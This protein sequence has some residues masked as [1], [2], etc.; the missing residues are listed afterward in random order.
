M[1]LINVKAFLER[2]Q[3]MVDGKHVNRRT[4]VLEFCDDKST[5]YAILS[6]RWIDPTEVDYEDIVD[7]AKMNVEERDEIRQRRGYR[8]ILDTCEQAKRDGYEWVWVD[9]CCIDKRSSAELSEAINSMY[10]WYANSRVCY[11]YLHDVDGSSIPA[12]EDRKKYP[13]SNGWPEWF[14]R[15]WTLQEMIA[16]SNVQFF[17]MNWT[18]IGDKQALASTLTNIT[19]VPEYI[20]KEGLAGNRP[21]V[22][23]IMS[24]AAYRKTSRVED[25]AYSLMGLLDVNMPMLY[26]EGRKAFHRL[27]LEIIR[28]SND[29]SIFAWGAVNVRIGSVLADDP[30]SFWACSDMELLDHDE[31]IDALKRVIPQAALPSIDHDCSD[32]FPITNRGI[33]NW[34][35][36][37]P[38][39]DSESVFKAY[40]PCCNFGKPATID[41]ALRNSN[42]Y[43]YSWTFDTPLENFLQFRQIYL[44]YQDIPCNV[45]FEIDDS[46]ITE[47]GFTC[48]E[49][50]WMEN[51]STLTATDT[52]RVRTY[53]ERQGNGR[54][55][56][57]F[58]HYFGQ[59]WIHLINHPPNRFTQADMEKLVVKGPCRSQS[60]A[61]PPSRGDCRGRIWVHHMRLPTSI[62][63]VRTH[64]V[65]WERSRI[66]IKLEI[67]PNYRCQN[68][69]NEWKTFDIEVCDFSSC[70]W[71][72]MTI[73]REPTTLSGT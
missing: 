46:A 59:D 34:M 37:Q 16:P 23:Q 26:G 41:L 3:M 64:R 28:T 57:A 17:N 43:R 10:R 21:C 1:R 15:G 60:M 40:L 63:I 49:L 65:V 42:F 8:K 69:L 55:A 11:T 13:K 61:D 7:L 18:Y 45:T 71:I 29:Q 31:F 14:S 62:W 25:R 36:L 47:N 50:P 67:F 44:R 12:K 32:V 53:S 48:S 35:L 56:V 51:K 38:Y 39:H 33:H 30:N 66:G 4:K 6:H 72:A 58:G 68:Y 70:L 27:Q 2:E 20:L 52:F 5:A 9:T 54:F 22:A 19:R 24:W 73:H